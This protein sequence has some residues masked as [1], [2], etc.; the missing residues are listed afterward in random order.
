[1]PIPYGR[2]VQKAG[3]LAWDPTADAPTR[4]EYARSTDC[5]ILPTM[6][7]L[8]SRLIL[9][10]IAV[11]AA[12]TVQAQTDWFVDA[13]GAPPGSGTL[14]DPYTS[15]QFGLGQATTLDGDRLLVAS[16]TYAESIDFQGKDV[17][18]THDGVGAMPLIQGDGVQ[19]A[20]RFVSGE[21]DSAR[22]V[23]FVVTGSV[24]GTQQGEPGGGILVDGAAPVLEEVTVRDCSAGTG[25]GIAVLSGGLSLLECEVLENMAT[26]SGGGILIEEGNLLI[27]GGLIRSNVANDASTGGLSGGGGL[28]ALDAATVTVQGTLIELNRVAQGRGLGVFALG[29]ISLDD[30][31]L[32]GNRSLSF[33]MSTSGGGGIYAPLATGTN[34]LIEGNGDILTGNAGGAWGGD[35]DR[36][37]LPQQ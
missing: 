18:V 4:G 1:M 20:V 8:L 14:A 26:G 5:P 6:R 7:F 21:T 34:C 17:V 25:G 23:R 31:V 37:D 27:Q 28:A 16:G 13:A 19:S 32:R 30:V 24:P 29:T 22:L 10:A 11:A 15:I 9:P 12:S 3:F 33:A 2:F 35:L 36:I